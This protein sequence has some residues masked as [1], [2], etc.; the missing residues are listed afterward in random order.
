MIRRRSQTCFR[1]QAGTRIR[2]KRAL[3]IEDIDAQLDPREANPY[4]DVLREDPRYKDL[5]KRLGLSG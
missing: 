1:P 2:R 5:L 4:R 3:R